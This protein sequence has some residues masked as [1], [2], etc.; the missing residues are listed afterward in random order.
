MNKIAKWL[1]VVGLLFTPTVIIAEDT[2]P[3]Q[4]QPQPPIV[5][6]VGVTCGEGDKIMKPLLD[7]GEIL[8]AKNIVQFRTMTN[9]TIT[10][11]GEI[12][13]NPTSLS[14]SFV[15]SF[16]DSTTKCYAFGGGNFMPAQSGT[17]I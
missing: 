10:A 5:L 12:W 17:N 7:A 4:I 11:N 15:F 13:I 6:P 9:D 16:P 8:V 14:W 1:L 3:E 2:Q